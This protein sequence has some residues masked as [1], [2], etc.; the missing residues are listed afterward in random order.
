MRIKKR[1]WAGR[2]VLIGTWDATARS[3]S[4]ADN[5]LWDVFPDIQLEKGHKYHIKDSA[6]E[7][8]STNDQAGN[9]GFVELYTD[10]GA[11]VTGGGF[12]FILKAF[13]NLING[14]LSPKKEPSVLRAP[15]YI[16]WLKISES[17][18]GWILVYDFFKHFLLFLIFSWIIGNDKLFWQ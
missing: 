12:K 8:W 13:S 14:W 3:G 9:M 7:T 16:L 10:E 11:V 5:V 1:N 18:G 17:S 4:G 15:I 6:P 2:G